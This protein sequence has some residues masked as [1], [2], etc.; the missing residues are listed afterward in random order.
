VGRRAASIVALAFVSMHIAA[1]SAVTGAA[2]QPAGSAAAS[3]R[4]ATVQAL[5][6]FPGFYHLQ[7]VVLRGEF[8][9]DG[10]T[11]SLR[12]DDNDVRVT[13]AEGVRTITGPVEIRGQL[14]D[15]GRLETSDPR[16][17]RIVEGADAERWPRPGE[18]LFVRVTSVTASQPVIGMTVRALALEPWRYDGQKVT[19]VGNFRGRNLFGDLAGAPGRS[20]YDFVVRGAEGAIWVTGM[21]PRGRGFDLDIDRRVDSD[22][23]L[24]VSGVLAYERGLVRIEAAQLTLAKAPQVSE[25]ADEPEVPPPPPP[26]LEIVFSSPSPDEVDVSARDP[27]RIQF[28]RGLDPKSLA[29]A[30]RVAYVGAPAGATPPMFQVNYDAASRAVTL[31]FAQPLERFTTIRVEILETLRAFDG[32]VVKPWTLTFS[33]GG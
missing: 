29:G 8:V 12:A 31:R 9:E 33:V 10:K 19:V 22:Q 18:E 17:T 25:A 23:W 11:I 30:F 3:R 20:R 5:R 16:A 24:E 21:R 26:P 28:S 15:V 6:Q 7:N 14:V 32:G 1:P 4:L 13:L 27:I 2:A